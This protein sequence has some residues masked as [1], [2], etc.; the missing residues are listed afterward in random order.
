MALKTKPN[1]MI[2]GTGPAAWAGM[3][4]VSAIVTDI[5]GSEALST[6]PANCFVMTGISPFVPEVLLV[7]SQVIAGM[8]FGVRPYTS[9]SKS[10]R[11][12]GR[13]CFHRLSAVVTRWPFFNL[14]GSGRTG[15]GLALASS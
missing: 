1:C 11:I 15:K 6:C 9:R 10:S 2:T 14:S 7:T 3:V 13:R 8:C 4:S 5:S 12:S